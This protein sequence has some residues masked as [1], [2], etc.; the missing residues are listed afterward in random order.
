MIV[1][2]EAEPDD[3]PRLLEIY[4][5]Y[6][7]SSVATFDMDEQ[8]LT[9]RKQWFLHYNGEGPHPLLVAE[10]DQVV[11]GYSSL[12]SFREKQAYEKTV[13]LSVYV[14]VAYQRHGLGRR[15]MQEI[16]R[17]GRA[18]GHHV[19][20]AGITRGNDVSVRLHQSLGFEYVGCFKEVGYK[21]GQWQDVEFYQLLLD[22][23]V[24]EARP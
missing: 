7:R 13:E 23:L 4:N 15:L 2:R 22:P 24:A 10:V 1:I 14:D 12:S 11:A 18:I 17:S 16:L 5:Y 9:Q 6:V 20:T 19:V 3:V 8:T 21:F